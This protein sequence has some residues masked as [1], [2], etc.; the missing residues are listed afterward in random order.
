M[1]VSVYDSNLI[2]FIY[3]YRIQEK[4]PQIRVKLYM[5]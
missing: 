1:C 2:C 3:I 5:F 4:S